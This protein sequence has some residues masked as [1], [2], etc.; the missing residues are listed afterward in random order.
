MGVPFYSHSKNS[1][2]AEG[3]EYS[4]LVQADP[5]AAQTDLFEYF[6]ATQIYNGIPTIQAKTHI[7]MEKAA[8]IMFWALDHDAQGSLSLVNAI[9]QT[10]K[11][12]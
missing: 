7:A 9:Y 3:I 8:G 11:Q 4:K 6:G 10:A 1:P 12:P 2:A 5:A